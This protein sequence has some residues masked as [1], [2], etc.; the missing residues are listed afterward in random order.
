MG[1][2]SGVV[3]A[4]ADGVVELAQSRFNHHCDD[5]DKEC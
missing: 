3:I 4:Y 2:S 5:D 1:G